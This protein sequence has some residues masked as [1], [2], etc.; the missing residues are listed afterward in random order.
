MFWF[1]EDLIVIVAA[2]GKYEHIEF[3]KVI[4]CHRDNYPHSENYQPLANKS[5]Q[6]PAC[7]SAI[8]LLLS[9]VM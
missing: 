3:S 1:Q 4:V 7:K 5:Y 9:D 6:S 2:K 8:P